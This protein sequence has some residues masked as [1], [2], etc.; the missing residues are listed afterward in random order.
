MS[1]TTIVGYCRACGKALDHDSVRNSGGTIYCAEHVPVVIN[2]APPP[3]LPAAIPYR[4]APAAASSNSPALAFVLGFIP[5]VGA[6]YN[7]QYAKGL[8][9]VLIFGLMISILSNGAAR[10][11]EPLFGILIGCFAFYMPFEAYHTAKNRVEGQPVDEFSSLFPFGGSALRFPVVAVLLIVF[12]VLFLLSNLDLLDFH[13]LLRYW[14]ILL[15]LLGGFMLFERLFA[16]RSASNE[17]EG[18]GQ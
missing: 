12:G 1:E 4:P 9:H 3:P 5:G 2:N 18:A 17:N 14:P 6:V 15:I 16:H 8:I 13:R 10:G 7:A 11:F